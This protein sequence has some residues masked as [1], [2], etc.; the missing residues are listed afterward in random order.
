MGPDHPQI[1]IYTESKHGIAFRANLD[2]MNLN[3]AKWIV[4]EDYSAAPTCASCHMSATPKQKVTHDVGMRISWNNRPE[5][6]IRP[7]ISDQKLGTSRCQCRLANP[8]QEH[9]GCLPQLPQP[10]L[11]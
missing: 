8:P 3:N 5:I 7:E 1:E 2:K 11:Y 10:E 9:G 4:G 6:S